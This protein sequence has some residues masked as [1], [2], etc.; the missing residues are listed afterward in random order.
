M[1]TNDYATTTTDGNNETVTNGVVPNADGTWT[2]LT[3]TQ[4]RTFKSRLSA[5]R[6]YG[7]TKGWRHEYVKS[8]G[9]MRSKVWIGSAPMLFTEKLSTGEAFAQVLFQVSRSH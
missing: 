4:S 7:T 9:A 2:A 8:G 6:W 5:A 3:Y 1:N